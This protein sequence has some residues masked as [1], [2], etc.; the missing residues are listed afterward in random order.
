MLWKI[1]RTEALFGTNPVRSSAMNHKLLVPVRVIW[2]SDNAECTDTLVESQEIQSFINCGRCVCKLP[3][4]AGVLL[5][6]GSE[7][8]GGVRIVCGRSDHGLNRVRIR[9]G[10]SASEAMGDPNNDHMV[11]DTMLE[12]P[13]HGMVNYGC[14]G[15]RFVRIDVDSEAE[16]DVLLYGVFAEA[17]YRDLEYVGRFQCSDERLNRIWQTGAYTVQLNM[18]DYI[19]DGIKRDRMVW[20]GDLNPEIRVIASVFDDTDAVQNSLDFVRDRTSPGE[21]VNGISSYSAWWVINQYDWYRYRGSLEY[22]R[23]QHSYLLTTLQLLCGYIDSEGREN[24]AEMRFLDWPS[25]DNPAAVHAGLHGLL[26]W[27]LNAGGQLCRVLGE[28]DMAEQCFANC[29]RMRKYCPGFGQSKVAA[30]LQVLA[31]QADAKHINNEQLAVDPCR[32]LSTFMGYYV[33]QARAQA[34]DYTGALDVIRRYWGGML[35]AGATTF[36]EDFD[37][38]WLENSTRIDELPVA[39]RKDIHADFGKHCYQGLRHSLCHGWAG[40]P[41]AWMSEHLLGIKPLEP[42]FQIAEIKPQLVGLDWIKGTVPS[43]Y[44]PIKVSAQKDSAGNIKVDIQTPE[45]VKVK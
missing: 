41:T 11:H 40:G 15:F 34:G 37:L 29:Q 19:Y 10:E 9:F 27:A 26:N 45:G 6:Y 5:D 33:L 17:V 2:R 39:G 20:V 36:W 4:G 13:S 38:D 12:L 14:T 31:G 42:G 16:G 21:P 43:P 22:L 35:D 24:C 28:H 3:P 30:A 18:Q 1:N 44:G 23:E 25:A 7:L 32:G 8:H